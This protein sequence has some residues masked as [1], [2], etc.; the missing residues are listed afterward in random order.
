MKQM[1]NLFFPEKEST[2]VIEMQ[3][4]A[5]FIDS[6][7][8][9]NELIYA[10]CEYMQ[11]EQLLIVAQLAVRWRMIS[12]DETLWKRFVKNNIMKEASVKKLNMAFLVVADE[13]SYKTIVHMKSMY[14]QNG[15]F[16][17]LIK[18]DG[19]YIKLGNID[20]CAYEEFYKKFPYRLKMLQFGGFAEEESWLNKYIK[21]IKIHPIIFQSF[22][23]DPNIFK[24]NYTYTGS[25]AKPD[26]MSKLPKFNLEKEN[27]PLRDIIKSDELNIYKI[28]LPQHLLLRLK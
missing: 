1:I 10:F 19:K 9:P 26:F 3:T 12:E 6:E 20:K 27:Y 22:K 13:L 2:N 21:N 17:L 5:E 15:F 11:P 4:I 16:P 23:F 8:L 24:K 7:L 14:G 25:E 18:K 28:I